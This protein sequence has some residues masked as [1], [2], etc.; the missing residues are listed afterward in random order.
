MLEDKKDGDKEIYKR[1]EGRIRR[2]GRRKGRAEW[3]NNGSGD[4]TE[5]KL[6]SR[7]KI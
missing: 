1:C 6:S 7:I 2:W 4:W 5:S 3:K